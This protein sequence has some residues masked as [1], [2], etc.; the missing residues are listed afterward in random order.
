MNSQSWA[1]TLVVVLIAFGGGFIAGRQGPPQAVARATPHPLSAICRFSPKG[2]CT[3][4][5][6]AEIDRAQ[7]VVEMQGFSFT[8]RPIGSAL[9]AAKKR[10]VKV[11]LVLDAAATSEHRGEAEY[12]LRNGVP[13]FLDARHAMAHNKVLLLDGRTLITGSFNFTRAAEEDNAEN[14]IVVHDQQDLQ[15]AY[16]ENFHKH[17]AHARRYEGR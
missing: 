16:E 17:L 3:D 11:T 4:E 10:G 12:V 15:D 8:S 13:V 1:A 7:H 9:V 5:I 6:V 2:G 14:L